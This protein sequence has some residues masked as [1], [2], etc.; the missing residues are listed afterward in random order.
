MIETIKEI[1][2]RAKN[3]HFIGIGGV[4]MS[5]LAEILLKM[6]YRVSGSDRV[7]SEVTA[8]LAAEGIRIYCGHAA[9]QIEGADAII[10]TAAIPENN[11][12]LFSAK[13]TGLPTIGRA[14]LLGWLMQGYQIRIGVAGTHGK[15]TTTSMLAMILMA[16]NTDPTVLNG[17]TLPVLHGSYRI[18]GFE[19]FLFEACEYKDSFLSF[20]PTTAVIGN[21][22]L[23]HVDYFPALERMEESFSRY[24][25]TSTIGI[26]NADDPAVRRVAQTYP[27]KSV[28]FGTSPNADYRAEK[29]EF[30]GFGSSFDLI[31][32]GKS[33]GR[34]VL[35]QPGTYNVYNALAA[36]AAAMENGIEFSAV[37][38]GLLN[39]HG[40]GRRFEYRGSL[41][42]ARVYDDY[43]HHPSEIKATLT[44]AKK[45]ADRVTCVFQPHTYSRTAELFDDFAK[46]LSIADRVILADIYAARE[47][48][49]YGISSKDLA[50]AV[51][52][53]EYL[54][55]FE[56]IVRVLTNEVQENDLVLLMGAGDI[57]HLGELLPLVCDA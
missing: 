5:S 52:S 38:E 46:A 57:N 32:Y 27:G 35:N 54:G 23:D 22:E 15:S 12:E 47:N 37:Q 26:L 4:S 48:N 44:A 6:G 55:G 53:A 36:I 1:M 14:E 17:A 40:A 34:V 11:P 8:R 42:G 25:N 3:I 28:W 29:I 19:Y 31:R 41:N 20:Y 18:G 56:E 49:I 50:N 21:I 13:E 33:Q 24:L 2:S 7:K 9:E 45:I 30:S 51:P 39:F 16:A 10:Y 43:A